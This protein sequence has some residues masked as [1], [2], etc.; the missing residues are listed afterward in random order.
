MYAAPIGSFLDGGPIAAYDNDGRTL[1]YSIDSSSIGFGQFDITIDS[2][3]IFRT[4]FELWLSS[5]VQHVCC[6]LLALTHM[7]SCLWLAGMVFPLVTFNVV[8]PALEVREPTHL[9]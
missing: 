2:G 4:S 1:M 6:G 8:A 5:V 7:P 9:S 3:K